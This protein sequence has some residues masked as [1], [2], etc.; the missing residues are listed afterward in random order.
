MLFGTLG[1]P[2]ICIDLSLRLYQ[3]I[4]LALLLV[5]V[6]IIRLNV[7]LGLS[8]RLVLGPIRGGRPS[9]HIRSWLGIV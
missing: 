2:A 9:P 1:Q 7:G 3:N 8:K 6:L 4:M 5:L